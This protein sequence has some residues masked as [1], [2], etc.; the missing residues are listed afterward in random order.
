M[1]KIKHSGLMEEEIRGDVDAGLRSRN[2]VVVQPEDVLTTPSSATSAF[3]PILSKYDVAIVL[4]Q[5]SLATSFRVKGESRATSSST[6]ANNIIN[7][8]PTRTSRSI[9]LMLRT[10]CRDR[11]TQVFNLIVL[12]GLLKVCRCESTGGLEQ[13]L[14]KKSLPERHHSIPLNMEAVSEGMK[15]IEKKGIQF[16]IDEGRLSRFGIPSFIH[17]RPVP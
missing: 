10:G 3:S 9:R 6:T 2:S 15:I 16:K 14:L 17:F 4:N 12:G 8:R 13:A 5:P 7:P 1:G 11:K